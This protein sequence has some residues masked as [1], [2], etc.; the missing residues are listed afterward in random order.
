MVSSLKPGGV[1]SV[2][3]SVTKPYLYSVLTKSSIV[4]VAVLIA[5]VKSIFLL[6]LKRAEARAPGRG[7]HAASTRFVIVRWKFPLFFLRAFGAKAVNRDVIMIHFETFRSRHDGRIGRQR[8]IKNFAAFIAEIMAML[9]HV[10]TEARRA[11]FELDLT[12]QAAFHER[13]QRVVNR[14]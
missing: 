2:S 10:W 1:D 12:N 9:L 13:I 14:G 11:A 4:S 5:F 3:T 8:D 6:T 7:V